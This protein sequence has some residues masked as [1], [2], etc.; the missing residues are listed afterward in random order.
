MLLIRR[1]Y[2]ITLTQQSLSPY[3]CKRTY[4][5]RQRKSSTNI[6]FIIAF[7]VG[8]YNQSKFAPQQSKSAQFFWPPPLFALNSQSFYGCKFCE[9][10]DLNETGLSH[11]A[12]LRHGAL[13]GL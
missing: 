2:T 3:F 7:A 4:F 9:A 1:R 11:L 6:I 5:S 8:L 12:H 10:L 13:S